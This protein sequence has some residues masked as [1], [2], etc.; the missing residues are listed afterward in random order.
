MNQLKHLAIIMDGNARWAALRNLCPNS[1]HAQ[2]A[3]TLKEI[4][5]HLID[6]NIEYVTA[7]AFSSEN[8]KRPKDEVDNLF[9][10][11]L[12][13][14]TDEL[15]NLHKM[16]VR[17]KIIGRINKIPQVCYD[18]IQNAIN[19]TENNKKITINIALSY[20]A[21]EEIIDAC[22]QLIKEQKIIDIENFKYYLYDSEMPNVDLLIRTGKSHRISNFLLWQIAYA[23][24]FFL[25]KYW[26]DFNKDDLKEILHDY[27]SRQRNFG[28]RKI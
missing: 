17:V 16:G 21:Q 14:L 18:A 24:L 27:K 13:F 5:P 26:P 2:G 7:F 6:Y 9:K 15:E 10:L 19:Y 8:W 25:D 12:E 1:G 23:E 3:K 22:N 11:L 28:A 20:S 4:V